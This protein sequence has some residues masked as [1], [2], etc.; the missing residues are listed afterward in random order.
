MTDDPLAG[1]PLNFDPSRRDQF[2]VERGWHVDEYRQALP[3]EPP[4]PP[5]AGGSWEIARQLVR[6]Y[7]FADPR[8]VR[9]VSDAL[10][11]RLR[12]AREIQLYMSV[13]WRGATCGC[14]GG[15]TAPCRATW[16]WG[17]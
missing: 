11:D 5:L 3:P 16:R 15:T 13:V 7:A 2:T 10:Y 1:Q 6:D 12:L 17:N 4:G 14:G 9:A 8:I